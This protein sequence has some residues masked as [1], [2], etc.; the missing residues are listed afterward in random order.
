MNGRDVLRMGCVFIHPKRYGGSIVEFFGAYVVEF[1]RTIS[2]EDGG[3]KIGDALIQLTGLYRIMG[4]I[5]HF[6]VKVTVERG[7]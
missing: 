5:L 6:A 1:A 7:L 3:G 2:K 4:L